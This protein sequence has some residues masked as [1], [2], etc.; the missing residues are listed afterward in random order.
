MYVAD[1]TSLSVMSVLKALALMV[2]VERTSMGLEYTVDEAVG[3]VPSVVYLIVAS[4][5]VQLRVTLWGKA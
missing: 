2:V 4:L 1:V 5:V 3:L